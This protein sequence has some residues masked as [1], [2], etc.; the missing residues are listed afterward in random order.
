MRYLFVL[1]LSV[2]CLGAMFSPRVYVNHPL[3]PVFLVWQASTNEETFGYTLFI[4]P[5]LNN[6]TNMQ[7][8][9]NVTNIMLANGSGPWFQLTVT[10]WWGRTSDPT[11]IGR[12]NFDTVIFVWQ[13]LTNQIFSETNPSRVSR[14]WTGENYSI[15][16]SNYPSLKQ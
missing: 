5:S 14:F 3:K 7:W 10:D 8:L 15:S 13:R 6:W 1:A 16:R 4:G 9:G 2:S 11:I 12:T